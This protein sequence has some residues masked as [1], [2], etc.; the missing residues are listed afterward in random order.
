MSIISSSRYFSEN[1][2]LNTHLSIL[3]IRNKR[4]SLILKKKNLLMRIETI[5]SMEKNIYINGRTDKFHNGLKNI[6]IMNKTK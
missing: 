2:F 4:L 6:Y 1:V 3:Q 5:I